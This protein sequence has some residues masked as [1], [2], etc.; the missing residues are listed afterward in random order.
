M[1]EECVGLT[2]T[3][4]IEMPYQLY[5]IVEQIKTFIKNDSIRFK[6]G[7]CSVDDINSKK[8]WSTDVLYLEF[9][10]PKCRTEFVLSCETYH[11]AGGTWKKKYE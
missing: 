10:C 8:P 4:K 9:E 11:G 5:E 2:E 7:N 6:T 3:Q 1:C